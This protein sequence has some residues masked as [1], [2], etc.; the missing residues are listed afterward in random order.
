M[1]WKSCANPPLGLVPVANID[2]HR[3]VFH[4][5]Q[6]TCTFL[7]QFSLLLVL[8][9]MFLRPIHL[10][11]FLQLHISICFESLQ[12]HL[13]ITDMECLNFCYP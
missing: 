5:A 9:W 2:L 6:K 7:A 4:M 3:F 11:S 13:R 12:L 8:F 10:R 1:K